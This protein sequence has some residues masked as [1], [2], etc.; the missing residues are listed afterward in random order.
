MSNLPD[1]Y[2]EKAPEYLLLS[3]LESVKHS[4]FTVNH[5]C[6]NIKFFKG[7]YLSSKS[8]IFGIE[9]PV[10]YYINETRKENLSLVYGPK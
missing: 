6:T 10:F 9:T 7:G 5:W 4:F 3:V 1:D 8:T 2:M